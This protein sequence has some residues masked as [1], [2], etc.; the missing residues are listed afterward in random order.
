M[1]YR[2][3]MRISPDDVGSRVVIRWRLPAGPV[4]D[5]IGQLESLS[6]EA[7]VV[8]K[9]SGQVVTIPRDRVVAAKPVPPASP[10]SPRRRSQS[11]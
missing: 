6:D 10:G 3:T 7:F 9:S 4:T 8:R 1:G 11:G 2:Y 5:V